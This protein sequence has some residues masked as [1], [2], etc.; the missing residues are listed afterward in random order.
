MQ[1]R[2]LK[3]AKLA[4]IHSRMVTVYKQDCVSDKSV[5]NWSVRLRAGG[6]SLVHD[7]RTGQAHKVITAGPID[8]VDDL[9]RSY[10]HVSLRM[11]A[12]KMDISVGTVLTIVHD[13][14][15]YQ[16]VCAHWVPKQHTD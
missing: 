6:D 7:P 2:Q 9:V 8:K 3:G 13:R 1:F 5:R 12:V 16:K 10:R 14:L 4:S 11:V 15:C